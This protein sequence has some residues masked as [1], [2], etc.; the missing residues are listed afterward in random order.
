MI[1]ALLAVVGVDLIVIVVLV[2]G[3][4]ARRRWLKRQTGAFVGAIRLRSGEVDG[5]GSSWKRG[6]GR[7]VRDVFVFTKSPLFVSNILT[8]TD[9]P[10]GVRTVDPD[11]KPKRLGD[12]PIVATLSS[13]GAI[14]EI[15]TTSEHSDLLRGPYPEKDHP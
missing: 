1:I 7:W 15:A 3:L 12:Q 2:G 6:Y 4:I 5:V 9:G 11:N 8:P 13:A 14:L 10:Y